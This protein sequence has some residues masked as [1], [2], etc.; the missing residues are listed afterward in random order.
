MRG[1]TPQEDVIQLLGSPQSV[2]KNSKGEEVWTYSKQS[3]D[4]DSGSLAGGIILFGGSKGETSKDATEFDLILTF[5]EQN[6]V[7]DYAIVSSKF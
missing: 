7:E 6:L 2:T 4:S 5:N 3:Y 1:Q